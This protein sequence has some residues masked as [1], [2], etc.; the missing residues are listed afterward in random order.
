MIRRNY[1]KSFEGFKTRV[2][3][4]ITALTSIQYINKYLFKRNIS[5]IK[6]R[7]LNFTQRVK[8]SS[9]FTIM[10]THHQV[11]VCVHGVYLGESKIM[12]GVEDCFVFVTKTNEQKGAPDVKR[13]HVPLLHGLG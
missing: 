1:A 13:L 8:L 9:A 11:V 2:L 12:A 10:W 4:K 3:A 7:L 5:N 6:I